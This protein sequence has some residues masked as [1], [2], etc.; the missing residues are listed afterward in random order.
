VDG[1]RMDSGGVTVDA[2][3]LKCRATASFKEREAFITIRAQEVPDPVLA[4]FV[5]VQLVKASV[6]PLPRDSEV[7]GQVHVFLLER[8]NGTAVVEVPGEPVSF[9]PKV[10]VSSSDLE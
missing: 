3:W 4:F 2:A 6:D 7:E 9:G 10:V 5:D 8:Q 1:D